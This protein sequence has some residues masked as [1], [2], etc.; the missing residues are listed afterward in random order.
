MIE[1]ISTTGKLKFRILAPT[2]GE[3]PDTLLKS[4]VDARTHSKLI[5]DIQLL[6]GNVYREYG[7]IANQLLPDGRHFQ[8][9]DDQSWHVVLENE[10]GRILGC[11]RYRPAIG[12]FE[13]LGACQSA[14]ASSRKYGPLLR[15]AVERQIAHARNRNVHYGEAGMWALRPEVRCSTAAV[16]VALMTFVLAERL[17]GGLGITTATT[18]HHSSSILR[19]LGGRRLGDLPAYY[20]PKYGC[21]IEILHFSMSN[22]HPQYGNRLEKLKQE[23]AD[24]EVVCASVGTRQRRSQFEQPL[25]ETG[26]YAHSRVPQAIHYSHLVSRM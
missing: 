20:E 12:G 4:S 19:R 14:L 13:Q 22:L 15:N 25:Y 21:V 17:G 2:L 8:S 11:S 18:R 9:L 6:R 10:N 5:F 23:V 3:V 26:L 1:R 24:I 16:N 7:P